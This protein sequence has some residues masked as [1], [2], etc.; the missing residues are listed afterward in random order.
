MNTIV[1]IL[2]MLF[3]AICAAINTYHVLK[4]NYKN[5]AYKIVMYVWCGLMWVWI[6]T[7]IVLAIIMH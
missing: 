3:F 4:S 7:L 5:V 6:I 2:V 1:F